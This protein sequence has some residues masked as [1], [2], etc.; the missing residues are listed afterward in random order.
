MRRLKINSR[1]SRFGRDEDGSVLVESILWFPIFFSLFVMIA[2][3]SVLFMNQARIKKIMQDGQRQMAVG[4]ID[5]CVDL[6]SW[7]TTELSS[8]V[9]SAQIACSET[10]TISNARVTAAARDL[11]LTGASGL[12]G[13][14]NVDVR[15]VYHQEVG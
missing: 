5:D 3:L 4:V 15:M 11:A 1:I 6:Q 10:A 2:D 12:F 7:L 9:P 8:F 13:Q 14:L